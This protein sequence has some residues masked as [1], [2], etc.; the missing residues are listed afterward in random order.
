MQDKLEKFVRENKEEFDSL[1]PNEAIWEGIKD[2]MDSSS[3]QHSRMMF[4]RAAAIILFAFSL[5][6]MFYVNKNSIIS[7]GNSNVADR[8]FV[9][10]EKYYTSI[11]TDR[12]NLIKTVAASYPDVETDFES[13]WAVLDANYADLKKE[14]GQ[15]QSDEV[16]NALIQNLQ[17]RVNLLN[18]Q[19]DVLKEM[20]NEDN[21]QVEI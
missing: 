8:E 12:Q 15:S 5:G 9:A 1:S 6:L 18:K 14:Y 7:S 10:T 4:W 13:D 19:M 17:A 2:K 3:K 20:K 11:I 16:L 21:T